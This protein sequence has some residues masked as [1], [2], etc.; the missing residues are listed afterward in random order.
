MAIGNQR[1][2]SMATHGQ[3]QR[4]RLYRDSGL[5]GQDDQVLRAWQDDIVR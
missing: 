4:K 2:E 3:Q 1:P 5:K